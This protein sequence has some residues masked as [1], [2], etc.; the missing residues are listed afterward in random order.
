MTLL[1]RLAALLPLLAAT[2]AFA[3]NPFRDVYVTPNPA[4][5]GEAV[6]LRMQWYPCYALGTHSV[7]REGSLITVTQSAEG[8]PCGTPPPIPQTVY[9]L[10]TPPAGDYIVRYAV[11]YDPGSPATIAQELPLQVRGFAA[12]SVP[13]LAPGAVLL[14]LLGLAGLGAHRLRGARG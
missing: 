1:R 2:S 3:G 4:V 6:T 9:A 13:L 10:G 12:Q 7:V 11:V 5:V 14:L 8:F